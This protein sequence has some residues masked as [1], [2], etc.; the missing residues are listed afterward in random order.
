MENNLERLLIP[1]IGIGIGTFC[2]TLDIVT[3]GLPI[4]SSTIA[5]YHSCKWLAAIPVDP[6]L[7]GGEY[8]KGL[9]L[10]SLGAAI[11]FAIKYHN[12][13]ADFISNLAS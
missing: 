13:I 1:A 5:I 12:E 2:G 8:F 10:Y 9:S 3:T 6:F 7:E 11:P 4:I